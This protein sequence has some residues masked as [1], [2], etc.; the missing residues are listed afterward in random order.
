MSVVSA[1][2]TIFCEGK[3]TSLDYQLLS[4]VV[5]GISGNRCTIVPAGG[6]FTFSIF[7]E[8]YFFPNE[9]KNQRFIIFRD[10]DFDVKPTDNIQLLAPNNSHSKFLLTHRACV[11]NYLLDS[12]LIDRYWREKYQEKQNNPTS[13]WGHKDSPGLESISVWIE[14]SASSLKDYQSV[15]W[16]LGDLVNISAARE[17]LKTTWTERSGVLPLSLALQDCISHALELIDRFRQ[18]VET[19]TPENFEASLAIYQ[20]QFNR[21]EFWMQKQYLIWFHG[22]DIQK[23]MQ[24]RKPNYISLKSFFAWAMT[25]LDIDRHPDLMELRTRIE[26]L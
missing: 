13:K 14:N 3:Q 6:K 4:R 11:E 7:A 8:G 5:E 20:Q 2:R 10:R 21:E 18:A 15:R 1:G 12:E 9:P 25:Q 22:K 26:E 19:V 23:E 16:A 17:Q 24:R